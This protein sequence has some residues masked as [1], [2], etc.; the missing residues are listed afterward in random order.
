MNTLATPHLL[1][2]IKRRLDPFI[3]RPEPSM[4]REESFRVDRS[5]L[6]RL[7]RFLRIDRDAHLDILVD[8]FG[9]DFGP[10][11]EDVKKQSRFEVMIRLRSSRLPYRLT[12]A[13]PISADDPSFPSLTELYPAADW[14]ERELFDTLGISA[15]GHPNLQRILLYPNFVGHPLR[16]EYPARKT[17]PMVPLR[18]QQATP[19]IISESSE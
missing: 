1:E 12:L 2:L 5:L 18:K 8:L 17:Q 6:H 9:V 15:E 14:Y 13:V 19:V 11:S 4:G 16:K 7:L 10:P 3:V